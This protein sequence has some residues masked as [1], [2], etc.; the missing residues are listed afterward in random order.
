MADS[1]TPRPFLRAE[2]RHLVM[3][4]YEI[5]PEV[6]APR[7]PA[8][9]TLDLWRGRAL[10]S[11]VGFRFLR[12]RVL[13][14]P[15]PFHRD[16]DEVNLRFYVRHQAADGELRRGVTFVRELVPRAAIALVARLAYNEPYAAVPMRSRVPAAV[17]GPHDG[18]LEY[19][20][21]TAAGWQHLAARVR[22]APALPDPDAEESFVAEHYWGYTRQ[23]DGG[24]VEYRVAHPRWRVWR[25]EAPELEVDAVG[26]Y[27]AA[28]AEALAA[29][30]TSA[31][32][33]EGSPVLVYRPRRLARRG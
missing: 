4:N 22:G 21:R 14:L 2:W 19:A 7:V 1:R 24:T 18:R 30:P 32:V 8:G 25:A 17:D 3:L 27:G 10:V 23:R 28:F 6:L 33:A 5:A 13:G 20:W 31:F 11:M 9:A 15:V 26:L 16:F 12:T 29:P